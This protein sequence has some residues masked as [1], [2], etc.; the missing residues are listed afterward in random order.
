[1]EKFLNILASITKT[2]GLGVTDLYQIR[3]LENRIY[4]YRRE[5][6]EE[7]NLLPAPKQSILRI[8]RIGDITRAIAHQLRNFLHAHRRSTLGNLRFKACDAIGIPKTSAKI[9]M[10][11]VDKL[12]R[13]VFENG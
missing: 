4:F 9:L 2:Y 13:F 12:Y 5:L 6:L 11:F 10:L 8:R 3:R 1:M 7:I